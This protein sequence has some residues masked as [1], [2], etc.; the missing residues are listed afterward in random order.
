M[1]YFDSGS[2]VLLV[3]ELLESPE[4]LLQ[5]LLPR[6]RCGCTIVDV[7]F[8]ATIE[9][10][11][12]RLDLTVGVG[13]IVCR[14]GCSGGEGAR[15]AEPAWGH[16]RLI[17]GGSCLYHGVGSE[18][19]AGLA[20]LGFSVSRVSLEEFF[21]GVGRRGMNGVA[22]LGRHSGL[23]E[24]EPLG[25]ICG[26]LRSRN[27]LHPAGMVG[28]PGLEG[29]VE[30]AYQLTG[31][32]AALV[33]PILQLGRHVIVSRYSGLGDGLILGYEP[34]A[35]S[36]YPRLGALLGAIYACSREQD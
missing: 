12:L 22:V 13:S 10:G 2:D 6:T 30:D 25:S 33:E 21:E 1:P 18:I 8:T 5:W 31:P 4:L 36:K 32:R 27:P 20:E 15:L 16:G 35:A 29:C 9:R 28:K 26:R 17:G 14:P 24:A 7:P 11:G 34:S 3:E 23:L 19:P